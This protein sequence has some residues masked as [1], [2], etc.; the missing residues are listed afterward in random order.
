M[1]ERWEISFQLSVISYQFSVIGELGDL[2][3]A[4]GRVGKMGKT[5]KSEVVVRAATGVAA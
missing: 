4:V 2:G 5:S 3:M 1:W